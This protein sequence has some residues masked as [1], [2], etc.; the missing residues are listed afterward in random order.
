VMSA[1]SARWAS[2]RSGAE[3]SDASSSSIRAGSNVVNQR[4]YVGR[5]RS[6]VFSQCW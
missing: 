3:A 2:R 6:S 1:A 4:R 5:S